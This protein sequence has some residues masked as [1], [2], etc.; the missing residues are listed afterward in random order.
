MTHILTSI[1]YFC[2][3]FCISSHCYYFQYLVSIIQR[4][5][6]SYFAYDFVIAIIRSLHILTIHN[7]AI[8]LLD[9][10]RELA[11]HNRTYLLSKDDV[12]K[13]VVQRLD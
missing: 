9:I 4:T 5:R 1:L 8:I 7:G 13:M 6:S 10:S 12:R 3:G 2:M 11:S